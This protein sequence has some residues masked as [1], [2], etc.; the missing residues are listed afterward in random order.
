MLLV[1]VLPSTLLSVHAVCYDPCYNTNR[2]CI[3]D[4]ICTSPFP[5]TTCTDTEASIITTN[6]TVLQFYQLP[7]LS[8]IRY[9]H[10]GYVSNTNQLYW[11]AGGATGTT[12]YNNLVYSTNGVS[13]STTATTTG[14]N[15]R[16][17]STAIASTG[18]VITSGGRLTSTD[19]VQTT[20]YTTLNNFGSTI[21]VSLKF[22]LFV[23]IYRSIQWFGNVSVLFLLFLC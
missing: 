22:I 4:G 23:L 21:N 18:M 14:F 11:I 6:G 16:Y 9:G 15:L 7:D 8:A 20:F 13:Y 2:P 5:T 1:V 19:V 17:S 12:N 3:N 10:T